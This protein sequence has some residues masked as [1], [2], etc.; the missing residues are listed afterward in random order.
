MDAKVKSQDQTAF[1]SENNQLSKEEGKSD[2]ET[3][4]S[5]SLP[6]S[7][8]TK[9][10]DAL[11]ARIIKD[12]ENLMNTPL[13][14]KIQQSQDSRIADQKCNS[15]GMAKASRLKLSEGGGMSSPPHPVDNSPIYVERANRR[16]KNSKADSNRTG[17][18]LDGNLPSGGPE[19]G[20]SAAR[21]SLTDESVSS[22]C[23]DEDDLFIVEDSIPPREIG[24]VSGTF[25][26]RP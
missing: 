19:A 6:L 18:V 20:H 16:L 26:Q 25:Q 2:P 24:A 21:D 12:M 5:K 4:A 3:V 17:K 7:V 15:Q 9:R 10:C 8:Q 1:Q 13:L 14:R 11:E 22:Y 23:V